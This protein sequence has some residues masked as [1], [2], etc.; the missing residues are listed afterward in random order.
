MISKLGTKEVDTPVRR[1][2]CHSPKFHGMSFRTPKLSNF[3]ANMYP[4][5]EIVVMYKNNNSTITV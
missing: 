1:T 5:A 2:L 4:Y 3:Q